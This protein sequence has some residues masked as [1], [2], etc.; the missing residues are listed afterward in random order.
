[1]VPIMLAV[2]ANSDNAKPLGL[3]K[4]RD[5]LRQ[6]FNDKSKLELIILEN[7]TF[8]YLNEEV[9]E[10][11]LAERVVIF[12]YGGHADGKNISMVNEKTTAAG[13][14]KFFKSL[15]N[16]QLIFL[17]GCD[18]FEQ[19]EAI[20]KEGV[21]A[22]IMTTV[23]PLDDEMAV[24]YANY[25][26]Y[27]FYRFNSLND[28]FESAETRIVGKFGL[29]PN[30]F[31]KLDRGVGLDEMATINRNVED[32]KSVYVLTGTGAG[33]LERTLLFDIDYTTPPPERPYEYLQPNR[34][35][36]ESL[37]KSI[38]AGDYINEAFKQ[39]EEYKSIET[40]YA[41]YV[42]EDNNRN[43][44]LLV[45]DV[46]AL[47]PFPLSFH[48]SILKA[49]GKDWENLDSEKKTELLKRQIITY[50]SLI[51]LLSF[52]LLSSFW[53][54]LDKKKDLTVSTK[55]WKV[56]RGFLSSNAL[57]NQD[58]NYPALLVTIREIFET[59]ALS[60]FISEYNL[61]GHIYQTEDEFYAT[62]LHMQGLKSS[63][64]NGNIKKL[65][66]DWLCFITEEMLCSI[67]SKA[68][69]VIRYKL[70]TV[71]NIEVSKSRLQGPSY[72]I[73]RIILDGST[74][75][76]DDIAVYDNYTDSRSVI[77]AKGTDPETFTRFLTL[78]PF[79]IDE[80]ALKGE[81]LSKL[82]F[83]SHSEGDGYVYR[84]AEN[85]D[86]TLKIGRD[87][88]PTSGKR[89]DPMILVNKRMQAIKDE[90]DAFIK[91]INSNT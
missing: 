60:P 33:F 63:I 65:N 84:W 43:F 75:E 57:N 26:Y 48:I 18:T 73:Q 76:E 27:A 90:L 2:F 58:I 20:Q 8:D 72:H 6:I 17:N 42:Q 7:A 79:I 49:N 89:N 4:E 44:N 67:L 54:E 82:F 36:I 25:F 22:A 19:A 38:T 50:D 88:Y 53:A 68:G 40:S 51:Q 28:S 46:L 85:P 39:S 69:F 64:G 13:L 81:K 86:K 3:I 74:V 87:T 12:H 80:N 77:L 37:S 61:L 47:L 15:P 71:K 21:S 29:E 1:M 32:R 66:I 30:Y 23:K 56:I 45:L 41:R 9:I 35:L 14:A 34:M 62:H 83:Y 11:Q 5:A 10:K 16:L 55:Q 78:S 31:I 24:H 91:L 70:T 59:N 52:T